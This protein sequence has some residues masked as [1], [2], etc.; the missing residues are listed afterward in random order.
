MPEQEQVYE[1]MVASRYGWNDVTEAS[2]SH[3]MRQA[4]HQLSM[5]RSGAARPTNFASEADIA[6]AWAHDSEA[7]LA[8]VKPDGTGPYNLDP[9]A[10][11]TPSIKSAYALLLRTLSRLHRR[12]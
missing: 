3:E 11:Y 5:C 6:S 8:T 4:E 2:P 9:A 12:E 10:G 7:A 1:G